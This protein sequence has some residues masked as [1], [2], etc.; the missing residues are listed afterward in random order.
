MTRKLNITRPKDGGILVNR[1]QL[2]RMRGP[3]KSTVYFF[4]GDRAYNY[5]EGDSPILYIGE[6]RNQLSRPLTSLAERGARILKK[7]PRIRTL[8][9]KYVETGRRPRAN[10]SEELENA[11]LFEFEKI[12]GEKPIGNEQGGHYDKVAYRK[13]FNRETVHDIILGFGKTRRKRRRHHRKKT[14]TE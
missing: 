2:F 14:K 3:R 13:W 12:H 1:D 4:V 5:E 7:A 9:V 6:T 11:F 10:I 8:S